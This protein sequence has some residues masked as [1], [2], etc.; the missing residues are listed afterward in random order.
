MYSTIKLCLT[1]LDVCP[2]LNICFKFS[3]H[4]QILY[5]V[6]LCVI[7]NNM[8]VHLLLLGLFMTRWYFFHP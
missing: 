4:I 1:N 5:Q 6:D 3:V 2:D 8:H 7:I